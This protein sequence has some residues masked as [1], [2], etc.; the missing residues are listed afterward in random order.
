MVYLVQGFKS[1]FN[2]R[3]SRGKVD[4]GMNSGWKPYQTWNGDHPIVLCVWMLWVNS[5]NR[6]RSAQ[7]SCWK[8]QKTWKNCSISWFTRS[9]SP[10]VYR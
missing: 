5:V 7:L 10:S 8:L 3:E 9:V 1:V 4:W 2:S 6:S